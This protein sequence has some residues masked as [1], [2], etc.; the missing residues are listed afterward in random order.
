MCT[1]CLTVEAVSLEQVGFTMECSC[2]QFHLLKGITGKLRSG[3]LRYSS[4]SSC[5]QG[6][7]EIMKY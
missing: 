7:D 5:M 4:V 6:F 3:S 2:R 1:I